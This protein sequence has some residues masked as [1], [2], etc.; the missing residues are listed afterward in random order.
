MNLPPREI[1]LSLF[2]AAVDAARPETCLPPY[3]PSRPKGKTV[4]IGMGKS[5]AAMAKTVE[6][7]WD[8][9]L[10]GVVVTRYGHGVDCHSVKVLAASHPVPDQAGVDA[11]REILSCIQGLTED[12]LVLCLISGGGSALLV[13]PPD[14]V[15][16]A[17][18]QALT[19]SLLKCGATISEINAV[20][21]QFSLV[22][23]G[24]LAAA[25]GPAKMVSL[26]ISDVPGDDLAFIASGPTYPNDT[27]A[28]QVSAILERYHIALSTKLARALDRS[29]NL[30]P[31]HR[32]FDRVENVLI[33][34]PQMSLDAAAAQAK[35]MGLSPLILGDRIEGESREVAIVM[36][37]IATQCAARRQPVEPPCVLLSGG[38]TTVTISG[39][40]K[41]GPNTEFLLSLAI[42]LNGHD[43]I[44]AIACDTDGIDGSEDNAG[45]V[46]T[47]DT[48]ERARDLDLSPLAYLS[49]NN[50]YCFFHS[51]DDLV[52]PGP[53]LTNV[54]DFRAILIEGDRM[55]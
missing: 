9:P 55:G 32:A 28:E 13:Q 41:G 39:N 4:V 46:V 34:T 48:L 21:K 12:D 31:H 52:V 20:R 47:P 30:P 26:I 33:A 11:T 29:Q 17:E 43:S 16:L 36:A 53:T 18:K 35:G 42:A 40:G 5:A 7:H 45:A 44:S 3:L 38:E 19:L 24:R 49:A 1:L 50:A 22:K 54:N 37:G 10:S 27:T 15:P 6:D 14:S 23:G 8:G 51:L 25:C 2:D